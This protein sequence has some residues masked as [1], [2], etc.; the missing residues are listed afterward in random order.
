MPRQ[1]KKENAMAERRSLSDGFKTPPAPV[2]PELAREFVY[3]EKAAP[4]A[5]VPT[6]N[7]VPL[8]TRIREDFFAA[9]KRASLERQLSKTEPH[10]LIEIL[11]QAVEPW[12]KSN[13]Y[14]R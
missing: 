9:L 11:E 10:T 12:L 1:P 6:F 4:A 3:G 2:D 8:S 5:T 7:R 13:G 14:L